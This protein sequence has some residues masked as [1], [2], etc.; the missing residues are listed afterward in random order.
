MGFERIWDV[1]S[2]T[3]N[4][5]VL[6]RWSLGVSITYCYTIKLLKPYQ[7]FILLMNL[8]LGQSFAM[9]ACLC[10]TCPQ[11]GQFSWRLEETLSKRLTLMGGRLELAFSWKLCEVCRTTIL[12]PLHVGPSMGCLG[13]LIASWLS[14]KSKCLRK[15]KWKCMTFSW[16]GLRNN[17]LS[18]CHTLLVKGVT[19]AC[20]VQE[21][22]HETAPFDGEVTKFQ[23][24]MRDG[25]YNCGHLWEI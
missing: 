19:K 5:Q 23:K 22:R 2:W 12:V 8:K 9:T 1:V 4:Q 21:E 14:S 25:R 24:S 11:L 3:L 10:S 20:Q 18:L 16:P 17:K 13:F 6:E 15:I 7:T